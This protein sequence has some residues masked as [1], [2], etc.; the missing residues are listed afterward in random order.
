MSEDTSILTGIIA[1][2]DSIAS[3]FLMISRSDMPGMAHFYKQLESA[4]VMC[5]GAAADVV[6]GNVK[7]DLS[8]AAKRIK[9]I[10]LNEE[11]DADAAIEDVGKLISNAQ[12]FLNTPP[13]NLEN[14]DGKEETISPESTLPITPLNPW[15]DET[16][17]AAYAEQQAGIIPEMEQRIL[18]YENSQDEQLLAEL[19]RMIHTLKG[20]SGVV[21]A[22][23]I[24][25]VCHQLEDYLV[26][27]TPPDAEVMLGVLDW[28]NS[29]AQNFATGKPVEMP[30]NLFAP[31]NA[32]REPSSQSTKD[33][34]IEEDDTQDPSQE[35]QN[36]G[37]TIGDRE[38][39]T[40]FVNEAQEHFEAADEHLLVLEKDPG[41]KDSISAVFRAFHTIK[42]VAGF[43]GLGPIGDL[44]HI[45]ETLLDEVRKGMRPFTGP[46]VEATFGGLDHLKLMVA[47]LRDALTNNHDFTVR[48]QLQKHI[49]AIQ[50]VL[51]GKTSPPERS[52]PK[53]H[54]Q[55]PASSR[56]STAPDLKAGSD[57]AKETKK[58]TDN[59]ENKQP[60]FSQMMKVDASRIDMLLDTIGELVIAES[61]VASDPDILA[62]KSLR[63]EKNLALL[64]KITRSLQDMGMSMRLVPVDP[65]F[66]K[67]ARLV[68]D[69]SHKSGK[70]VNFIIEGGDTEIDKNMVDKLGDPLV[71]MIRNSMDHG[72]EP[73]EDRKKSGKPEQGEIILRA[74]HKGG[75]ILI[76]IQ[77]DGRGLNREAI[78]AK[79]KE[80]G[81]ISSAEDMSELE[82]FS[83]IFEPGF[84]TAAQITEISGRGV[85]MDVVRRN[86]ESLRGTIQIRSEKGLGSVFTLVLPLTTA[87]IDGM[88]ARVANEI[89]ILPTLSILESFRPSRQ[90]VHTVTGKGEL[91][92]F[93]GSLLPM[94]RIADILNVDNAGHDPCKGI[95]IVIEEFGKQWGLMVDELLGQQQVVIKSLGDGIGQISCVTGASILADGKPGLIL[96]TAAI[97]RSAGG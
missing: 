60:A 34:A 45:A 31:V 7:S 13:L 1:R 89:F 68:R 9:N 32:N 23:A 97:I 42:G 6:D 46:A 48:P 87:I 47:D 91:V 65:V 62:I 19:K 96:D 40:D 27:S 25:S 17:L 52:A 18:G 56:Q 10:I 86:I 5:S 66:R 55:T 24:E 33:A 11:Q 36:G 3:D 58:Q 70:N 22:N 35:R 74:Y 4:V 63:I 82:V 26:S 61:I 85:G 69:L 93:R 59:G 94:H 37:I 72:I 83:L 76:E 81:L 16:I 14:D 44:A 71:H 77:D 80:R 92:S 53:V 57:E 2:V 12:N 79:A 64:G 95:I 84:S 90:Q 21:G 50:N 39:A 78:I 88:L 8:N 29:A 54:P 75:N 51:D 30:K 15:V 41:D 20:E 73:A 49:T 28:I 43:L 67:M 38:L